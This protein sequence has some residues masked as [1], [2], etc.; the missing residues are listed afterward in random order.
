MARGLPFQAPVRRAIL[1]SAAAIALI[2]LVFV[3]APAPR[4]A[5]AAPLPFPHVDVVLIAEV[6]DAPGWLA[7]HQEVLSTPPESSKV[8][9][10]TLPARTGGSRSI[11]IEHP[12]FTVGLVATAGKSQVKVTVVGKVS[13]SNAIVLVTPFQQAA[14]EIQAGAVTNELGLAYGLSTVLGQLLELYFDRP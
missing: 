7:L 13:P 8:L 12:R 2:L 14:I 9:R 11:D 4:R 10:V 6:Q 3:A 5:V 1:H